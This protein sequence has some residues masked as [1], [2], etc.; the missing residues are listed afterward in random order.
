MLPDTSPVKEESVKPLTKKPVL[1]VAGWLPYWSK[2]AGTTSLDG[3]IHLFNEI[4]P[5]ALSVA[6]DGSLVDK[7]RIESPPWP[8][9]RE[10]ADG[11]QVRIMPTLLWADALAMH[12]VFMDSSLLHRHI[13]AIITL[14]EQNNFPGVDIDYEGKDIAD[15]DNFSLFLRTLHERLIGAGKSVSCTVEARADDTVPFGWRGTR[16]MSYANDFAILKDYCD[17]VRIM[18]YDQVFQTHGE[19]Q[20]F[21]DA[22]ETPSA[23]HS[24]IHWV[25]SVM[26][27]ALK[28]ITPEK[29][30]M[31]VPTYGW[32]FSLTKTPTGYQY[33]RV[34]SIS[35]EDALK[36]AQT[37]GVNVQRSAGG[38]PTF[39]YKATDGEHIV[40]FSDDESIRQKITLAQKLHLKGVSFFKLDGLS[41][42]KLF[43]TLEE[44]KAQ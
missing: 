22:S 29:L 26:Q 9:L 21:E 25:E 38:E 20:S 23:P 37:A 27:Y 14:L 36:E 28:Y 3:K 8:K 10:Q 4:N 5:F 41:D 17:T 43:S 32:E 40:T 35:Y 1:F 19:H 34:R 12:H 24:D 33:T 39:I 31:G 15:R 44:M 2:E 42:P 18:A 7:T 13:E 30:I 11:V 6:T 16:A